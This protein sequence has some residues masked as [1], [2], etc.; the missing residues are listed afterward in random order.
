M[1]SVW[2]NTPVQCGRTE[3]L[4]PRRHIRA[5]LDEAPDPVKVATPGWCRGPAGHC[6]SSSARLNASRVCTGSPWEMIAR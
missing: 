6:G 3:P 5:G 4:V 2:S 1:A